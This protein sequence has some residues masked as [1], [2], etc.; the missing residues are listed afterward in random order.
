MR[1]PKSECEH[2]YW[3]CDVTALTVPWQCPA[4]RCLVR[5]QCAE[6]WI[7][8]EV[9]IALGVKNDTFRNGN[10]MYLWSDTLKQLLDYIMDLVFSLV[11]ITYL[12]Q[13]SVYL[14]VWIRIQFVTNCLVL[15]RV[16]GAEYHQMVSCCIFACL[17]NEKCLVWKCLPNVPALFI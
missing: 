17:L 2:H 5:G 13:R 6:V 11:F 4:V 8:G 7:K 12:V 14:S 1:A 16:W 3:R 9:L 15:F 10:N